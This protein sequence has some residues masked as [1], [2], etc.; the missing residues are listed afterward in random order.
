MV[1]VSRTLLRVFDL[2]CLG[3][4]ILF[5]RRYRI[6][7]RLARV[8]GFL[9]LELEFIELWDQVYRTLDQRSRPGQLLNLLLGEYMEK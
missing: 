2:E 9:E 7:H 6:P 3:W 1:V 8:A 4:I 5:A